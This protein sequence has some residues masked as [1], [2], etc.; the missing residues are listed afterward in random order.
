MT[1]VQLTIQLITLD[2]DTEIIMYWV[3]WLLRRVELQNTGGRK[4]YKH[5][6]NEIRLFLLWSWGS[7]SANPGPGTGFLSPCKR[8]VQIPQPNRGQQAQVKH[9][10]VTRCSTTWAG[11]KVSPAVVV[12]MCF[13][14]LRLASLSQAY[15]SHTSL[16]LIHCSTCSVINLYRLLKSMSVLQH[17]PHKL[18]FSMVC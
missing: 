12:H 7:A 6:E 4:L 5:D 8:K 17:P 3:L 11:K 15:K 16:C 2:E 14:S 10:P 13:I 9:C 18:S 1:T